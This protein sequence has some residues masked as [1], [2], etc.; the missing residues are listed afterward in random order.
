MDIY[1]QLKSSTKLICGFMNESAAF[2]R[3]RRPR[4]L[5]ANS[6]AMIFSGNIS[7]IVDFFFLFPCASG[8][9]VSVHTNPFRPEP[10]PARTPPASGQLSSGRS[11]PSR[12]PPNATVEP[13]VSGAPLTQRRPPAASFPLS[14]D[15]SEAE[16][17]LP[18]ACLDSE[19]IS[20]DKKE[21]AM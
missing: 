3:E 6:Y 20:C 8:D 15:T 16:L 12:Q 21:M 19:V 11:A 18:P 7:A 2:P 1:N 10:L 13:V 17:L 9:V 5:N 14:E 4:G